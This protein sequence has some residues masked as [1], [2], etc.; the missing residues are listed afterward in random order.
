MTTAGLA[1]ALNVGSGRRSWLRNAR[2]RAVSP[3]RLRVYAA[4]PQTHDRDNGRIRRV[5]V[6]TGII[7]TV[8]GGGT[9]TGD[10]VPALAASLA[11]LQGLAADGAGNLYVGDGNFSRIRRIDAVTNIITTVAGGKY[12][13][14]GDGGLATSA[15]LSNW[16]ESIA[17]DAAGNIFFTDT[18]N[19]RVRRVDAVTRIITTV[20]GNGQQG[21]GDNGPATSVSFVQP[22]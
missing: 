6:R 18:N 7:T 16:L 3:E 1:L 12:G 4:L 2:R 22:R 19:Y 17:L 10:G 20:A 8:A 9:E 14:S 5:D 13:F 21:S 15:A 11:A